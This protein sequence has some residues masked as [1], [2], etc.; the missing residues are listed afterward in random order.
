MQLKQQKQICAVY[1]EET[2]TDQTCLKWF[3]KIHATDVLLDD[4]PWLG[5]SVACWQNIPL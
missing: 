5:R 2:V 3:E 1:G 4:A